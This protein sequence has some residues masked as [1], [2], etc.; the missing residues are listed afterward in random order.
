MVYRS[1]GA[2]SKAIPEFALSEEP[3]PGAARKLSGKETG[4]LAATAC[5]DPPRGRKR[6]ALELLADA[7]SS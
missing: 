7:M 4:L 3:R 6:W 2:L 1:S 5:S